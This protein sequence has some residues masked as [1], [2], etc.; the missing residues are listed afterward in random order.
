[1][2]ERTGLVL[3]SAILLGLTPDQAGGAVDLPGMG[4]SDGEIG[5]EEQEDRNF[6]V[7][8]GD[9]AGDCLITEGIIYKS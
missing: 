4:M 1:M 5:Y 8:G 7:F 6:G 3:G 2:P 9:I